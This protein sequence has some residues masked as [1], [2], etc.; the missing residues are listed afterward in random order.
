MKAST[1]KEDLEV[2]IKEAIN[3]PLQDESKGMVVT[4]VME[5]ER[6]LASSTSVVLPTEYKQFR[7]LFDRTYRTLLDYSEW[8]YT[9]P[10]KEGKEPVPQK[11]Y[12]VLGNEEE[13]LKEYIEENLKKGYIRPS[14]SLVGYPVLFIKKKGTIDLRMCIDFQQLNNITV[15][16]SYLLSLIIKIQDKVRNKK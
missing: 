16:D 9:I 5:E 7:D 6:Q 12:L 14:A 4:D 10:L 13:A 11:I 2:T 8:D 1:T 3:T 15:K